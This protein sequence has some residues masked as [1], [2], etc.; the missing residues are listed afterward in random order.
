[1]SH[2]HTSVFSAKLH[3]LR[4]IGSR[5]FPPNLARLMLLACAVLWGTSYLVAK[6]VIDVV[7][8]NW[9]MACRTIIA[10]LVMLALFHKVIVPYLRRPI[11][12]PSLIVGVTY[13][14]T[15]E[16]QIQG[17]V[18]IDPGRSAFL[19]AGYCVVMPFAAWMIIH[20]RPQ[21]RSIVAAVICLI[22]VGFVSLKAGFTG[23]AFGIG[24]WLSVASAIAYAYNV[25]FLSVWGRKFHPVAMT[26]VQFVV[27]GIGFLTCALIVE[28]LPN[29]S[30]LHPNVIGSL[31]FLILGATMLGQIFQN[32]GVAH[33]PAAQASILMSL[34]SV[35]SVIISAIFYGERITLSSLIG[36]VLIFTAVIISQIHPKNLRLSVHSTHP[37]NVS[38]VHPLY[39][40]TPSNATTVNRA[41]AVEDNPEPVT[42]SAEPTIPTPSVPLG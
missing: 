14:V 10:A 6:V 4:S 24:D 11:L 40:Q 37:Q 28:P 18:T 17:L 27:A 25:M 20:K 7:G 22:G 35:F 38:K 9:V 12:I 3:Q 29:A 23:F 19:S 5:N 39:R 21:L 15:L 16:M 8:P 42:V 36:F 33:L 32:I 1:M 41:H 31:L 2:E 30:W 34:E 13:F 26:F